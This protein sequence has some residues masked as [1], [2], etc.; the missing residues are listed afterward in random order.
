MYVTPRWS[1][2]SAMRS[3]SSTVRLMPSSCE[4]SRSVVSKTSTN[5]RVSC[6]CDL[7]ADMFVPVL[8][9]VDLAAHGVGED[10]LDLASDRAGI[11]DLAIVDGADRHDLGGGPREEALVR[12]VQVAPHEVRL[13]V[14]DA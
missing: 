2:C 7:S 14:L 12:R 3:L 10:L 5:R 1:S 13:A 11:A 4:P 9:L 6:S 8:V